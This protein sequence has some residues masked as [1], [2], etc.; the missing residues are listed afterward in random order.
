MFYV[1]VIQWPGACFGQVLRYAGS[2]VQW[3]WRFSDFTKA[4]L[5]EEGSI[6]Y[7]R[8]TKAQLGY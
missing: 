2:A 1:F 3:F 5:E 8:N 4:P 7:R 6:P